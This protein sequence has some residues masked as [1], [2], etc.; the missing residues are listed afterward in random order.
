VDNSS[1]DAP[2]PWSFR[3]DLLGPL[4]VAFTC[5]FLVMMSIG[6][7]SALTSGG[8]GLGYLAV[9]AIVTVSVGYSGLRLGKWLRR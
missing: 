4:L 7:I 9:G 3:R 1:M 5:I 8:L 6:L 2:R